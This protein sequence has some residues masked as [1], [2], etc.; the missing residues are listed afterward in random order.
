MC[1][2]C[3]ALCV[4]CCVMC[5]VRGAPTSDGENLAVHRSIDIRKIS[6]TQRGAVQAGSSVQAGQECGRLRDD[7]VVTAVC[8]GATMESAAP[9]PMPAPPAPQAVPSKRAEAERAMRLECDR[10]P[11]EYQRE[12]VFGFDAANYDLRGLVAKM[13]LESGDPAALQHIHTQPDYATATWRRTKS[14]G[15]QVQS[16][17]WAH[18]LAGDEAGQEANNEHFREVYGRFIGEVVAAE[19]GVPELVYQRLPALRCHP[20]GD[21]ALGR[22][23]RDEMY[24]RQPYEINIWLPLTPVYGTNSLW[25]ES[26]RDQGD[27][28]PLTADWGQAVR[29]WGSQ[30]MH[31]TY[32]NTEPTA[33]LSI[34]ALYV[35]ALGLFVAAA[36][37][38]ADLS[39]PVLAKSR[40]CPDFRVV[41]SQLYIDQYVSPLSKSGRADNVRGGSYTDTATERTWRAGRAG[42][43][44]VAEKGGS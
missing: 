21:A 11:P 10:M 38:H 42:A 5:A 9:A 12:R 23:H 26:V 6:D 32:P 39:M 19:L 22:P 17:W 43:I 15:A 27:L 13:L 1:A 16:R 40:A 2:V 25:V 36:K 35:G 7:G 18:G 37:L 44:G 20:P 31:R 33:R 24:L 28:H 34:G 41:P 14:R 30:V 8:C 4:L 3:C 29:F